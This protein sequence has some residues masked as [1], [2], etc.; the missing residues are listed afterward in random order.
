MKK[1]PVEIYEVQRFRQWWTWIL[2]LG[3]NALFLW[4][5]IQQLLLGKEWGTNP[6]NDAGLIIVAAAMLLLSVAILGAKLFTYINEEG[7]YVKFFPFHFRYKFYDWSNLHKVYVRDYKPIKE[8]G[9]WGIRFGRR[10]RA[11]SV[12]GSRGVRIECRDGN[13]FL[14]GSGRA[15][16]LARCIGECMEREGDDEM[17]TASK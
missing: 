10:G 2:L 5:C 13:R 9:G 12:A 7:V 3:I 1:E 8:F 11:Y 15:A 6:M 16:E 17:P 14:L 4:G